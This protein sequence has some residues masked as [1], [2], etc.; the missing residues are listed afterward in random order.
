VNTSARAWLGGQSDE[1]LDALLLVMVI[2]GS[3]PDLGVGIVS[4]MMTGCVTAQ[5]PVGNEPIS[6]RCG[7]Q[8]RLLCADEE[9]RAQQLSS[10]RLNR[11]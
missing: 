2:G 10:L 6:R 3:A 7:V 1:G 4:P 11:I 9:L 8:G 5:A